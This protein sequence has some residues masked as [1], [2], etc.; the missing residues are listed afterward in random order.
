MMVPA[1]AAPPVR[2]SL[3]DRGLAALLHWG[4]LVCLVALV[5][6]VT[7]EVLVRFVPVTSLGW[8]DEVVELAF[9][10][11]VFLGTAALWRSREHITIDFIPQALAGTPVGRALEVIISLLALGFL[12][13]FT[14]EGWLLTLQARG[15]TT[16]I[17][18]L[19]KPWWYVS[20][21]ISGAVMIAYTLR[22]FIRA[23]RPTPPREP[24]SNLP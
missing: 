6:L 22:R 11:M 9:A 1:S 19:P 12:S 16:P 14:W 23:L 21:P 8:A 18:E 7:A 17:L 4:S 15:N 20:I 5:I 3:V 13:V 24:L 10:W 2:G